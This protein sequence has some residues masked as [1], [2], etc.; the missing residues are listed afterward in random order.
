MQES[1]RYWARLIGATRKERVRVT[2]WYLFIP[3]TTEEEVEY[4]TQHDGFLSQRTQQYPGIALTDNQRNFRAV[5]ANHFT[6][7]N[8][9]S[10]RDALESVF[11]NNPNLRVDRRR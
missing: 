9:K 2:R 8:H 1:E 4:I 5:G 6:E 10:T 3:I 11:N 7:G